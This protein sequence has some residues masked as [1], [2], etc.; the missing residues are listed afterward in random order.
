MTQAEFKTRF[1]IMCYFIT[2]YEK[3]KQESDKRRA[4]KQAG[5]IYTTI[6]NIIKSLQN[7]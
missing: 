6:G 3:F 1:D 7:H 5:I 2:K 4:M